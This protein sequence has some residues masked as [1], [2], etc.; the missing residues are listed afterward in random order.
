MLPIDQGEEPREHP[1]VAAL[2]SELGDR[3]VTADGLVALAQAAMI[4]AGGHTASGMAALR[5]SYA[6]AK[7]AALAGAEAES[8]SADVIRSLFGSG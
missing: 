2:R 5:R 1:L 4:A 6:E 3:A 7:A 8:S